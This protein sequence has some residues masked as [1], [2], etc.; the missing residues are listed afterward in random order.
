MAANVQYILCNSLYKVTLV[1]YALIIFFWLLDPSISTILLFALISL[2]SRVPAMA[3]NF[4]K[5]VEIVDF[6]TVMIAINLGG[7]AGGLYGAS[8][9][10]ISRFLGPVEEI[11]YILSR[12]QYV[13]F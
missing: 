1:I 11:D 12:M 5:D 2:W 10:L 6:F 4:T 7:I 3:T 13:S 8:I 9:M